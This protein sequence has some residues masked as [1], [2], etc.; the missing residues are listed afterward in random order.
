MCDLHVTLRPAIVT[1]LPLVYRGELAYIQCWELA[2]ESAWRLQLERNLAVW[3][4]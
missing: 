4:R 2:H 1:D 3:G